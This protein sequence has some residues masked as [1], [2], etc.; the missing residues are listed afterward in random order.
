[1]HYF[2]LLMAMFIVGSSVIVGKVLDHRFPLFFASFFR[3]FVATILL[4]PTG[5]YK[6]KNFSLSRHDW[7][8]VFIMAFCGQIL[9]TVLLLL[10]LRYTS[11]ISAGTLTST[12]PLFM[13][14]F[15]LVFLGE[16][17]SI[18]QIWALLL[19]FGS[20]IILSVDSFKMM[21]EHSSVEW[22]GNFFIIIAV[23]SEAVFLLFAKKLYKDISGLE[24]TALLSLLGFLMCLPL[25]IYDMVNF[26]FTIVSFK[27]ILAILYLGAIYTDL[28][29][30]CWFRGF[31]SASGAVASASTAIMP[32]SA[33]L[34]SSFILNESISLSQAIALLTAISSIFLLAIAEFRKVKFDERV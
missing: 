4:I 32:L 3:F 24:L 14:V 25:A 13:A 12:T 16:K 22:L 26:N 15:S 8:I 21:L 5:V 34:L 6:K 28:A 30:I 1:M 2:Y 27:D 11:G 33:T 18:Q 9:F 29:Y 17:F 20:I 19:S 31:A 23:A 10:G 7:Y